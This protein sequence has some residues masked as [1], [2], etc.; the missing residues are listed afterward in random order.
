[1][2]VKGLFIAAAIVVAGIL[3]YT[4][5]P[6]QFEAGMEELFSNAG[7]GKDLLNSI[8]ASK[9]SETER[10]DAVRPEDILEIDERGAAPAI[11]LEKDITPEDMQKH[12]DIKIM[13]TPIAEK[14]LNAQPSDIKKFLMRAIFTL[15]KFDSAATAVFFIASSVILV[16]MLL[17][18]KSYL[19]WM[20]LILARVGYGLGL[21]M[22][23]V[24]SIL[25]S[26]GWLIYKYNFYS[27]LNGIF[28]AGP[29]ALVLS[30]SISLKIYD[31]NNPIWNRLIFTITLLAGSTAL[32]KIV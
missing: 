21:T 2:N 22:V 24:A 12:K 10:P 19:S 1:M 30:S 26:A 7:R 6:S 18:F 29:L 28:F 8:L 13:M 31:F 17:T 14:L 9:E 25:T 5:K 3:I 27:Q 4:H 15:K 20:S 11:E 16:F 23:I 32:T